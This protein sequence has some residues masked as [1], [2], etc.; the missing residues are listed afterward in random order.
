MNN[1]DEK[2]I[3]YKND[4]KYKTNRVLDEKKIIWSSPIVESMYHTID[5]DTIKYRIDECIEEKYV[6][7]DL[8]HLNLDKLPILPD[9]IIKSVKYL[10]LGDNNL[11]IFPDLSEWTNLE[12]IEINHNKITEIKNLPISLIELSIKDNLLENIQFNKN[13]KIE[14]LDIR[15]NKLNNIVIPQSIKI[16]D[17]AQNNLHICIRNLPYIEKLLCSSNHIEQITNCPLLEYL[18]CH[19]NPIINI[20]NCFMIEHLVCSNT[21]L[22]KIPNCPKIKT[23]ECFY[24]KI[25]ELPY[26]EHLCELLCENNQ[27]K[28]IS[29]KYVINSADI[30]KDKLLHINFKTD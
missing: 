24:T 9:K 19:S 4:L 16:L 13:C 27:I 8:K 17:I 3:V 30:Y 23:I 18:D 12:M 21:L 2:Y 11:S 20:E 22:N 6:T 7:L 26:Y 25:N 10:F 29:S 15:Q 14:R 28:K 5:L 1:K